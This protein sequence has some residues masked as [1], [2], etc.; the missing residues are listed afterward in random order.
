MD[1][2]Q[3]LGRKTA[4]YE[5]LLDEYR[6]LL[7]VMSRVASGKIPPSAVTVSIDGNNMSWTAAIPLPDAAPVDE[8]PV[9]EETK[10]D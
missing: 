9:T 1:L 3:L 10:A 2:E 6:K 4:Q 7:E 8:S 5:N